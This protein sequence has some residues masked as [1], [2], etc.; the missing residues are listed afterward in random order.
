MLRDLPR[1]RTSGDSVRRYDVDPQGPLW[2][3][4]M[5]AVWDGR[6]RIAYPTSEPISA[7]IGYICVPLV[8]DG[9][10]LVNRAY[11]RGSQEHPIANEDGRVPVVNNVGRDEMTLALVSSLFLYT[12]SD[13]EPVFQRSEQN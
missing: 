4:V 8:G 3:I 11:V 10:G 13:G 6:V 12:A 7:P 9:E 2:A 5:D 1:E